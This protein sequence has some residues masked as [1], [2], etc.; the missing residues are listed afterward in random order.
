MGSTLHRLFGSVR[1]RITFVA[2][3]VFA[4]A[5]IV[6]AIAIVATVRHSLESRAR[7]D[8]VGTL[9]TL[10]RQLQSGADPQRVFIG[11]ASAVPYGVYDEQGHF[12]AGTPAE[13]FSVQVPGPGTGA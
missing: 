7:A 10:S 3:A 6:G 12:I 9:D 1:V 11:S 5:T 4:I 8:G 2:T 13:G